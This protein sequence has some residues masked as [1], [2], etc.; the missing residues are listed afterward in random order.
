MQGDRETCLNAGMDGYVTKPLKAAE[1][2]KAIEVF[3]PPTYE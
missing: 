2:T 3:F 1:L